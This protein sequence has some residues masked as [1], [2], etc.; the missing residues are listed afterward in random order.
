MRAPYGQGKIPPEF[1]VYKTRMK[2]QVPYGKVRCKCGTWYIDRLDNKAVGMC[3]KCRDEVKRQR[4]IEVA[5]NSSERFKKYRASQKKPI[6]KENVNCIECGKPFTTLKG[7]HS[8]CKQCRRRYYNQM[9]YER[10]RDRPRELPK[11]Y[12]GGGGFTKVHY[13]NW[14]VYFAERQKCIVKS[15]LKKRKK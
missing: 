9:W 2:V 12:N 14:D 7:E 13:P 3:K 8:L 1:R 6:I 5:K 11:R 15:L 4:W 10:Q